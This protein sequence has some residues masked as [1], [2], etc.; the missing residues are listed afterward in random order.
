MPDN[1]G[2]REGALPQWAPQWAKNLG[3]G[4]DAV[5]AR[6]L[7][8]GNI[9]NGARAMFFLTGSPRHRRERSVVRPLLHI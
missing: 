1:A 6:R 4:K 7:H 5:L 9:R 3:F 8:G 2:T